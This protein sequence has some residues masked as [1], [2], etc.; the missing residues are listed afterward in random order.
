MFLLK[1][2]SGRQSKFLKNLIIPT[3]AHVSLPSK[4]SGE[5]TRMHPEPPTIC[6]PFINPI[7]SCGQIF[8]ILGI[9]RIK[10]EEIIE[11]APS[12]YNEFTR[13]KRSGGVRVIRPPNKPLRIVQR[14]IYRKLCDRVRHPKWVTG[15][16][17]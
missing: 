7:D 13:P 8:S 2:S 10:L 1:F 9:P 6:R 11:A 12:S 14:C 15:G 4:S 5:Y 17:R 3:N 16:V